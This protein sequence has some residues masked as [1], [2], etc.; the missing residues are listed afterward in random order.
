M[1]E[2]FSQ[3]FVLF[4]VAAITDNIVLNRFLG[5]CPFL[6]VSKKLSS[7]YQ[8]G[9]AVTF[10]MIFSTFITWAINL[11]VLVPFGLEFLKIVSFILIIASLVQF[12]ELYLKKFFSEIY[13]SFGIYLPLITTNCAILGI[14]FLNIQNNHRLAESIFYPLGA[15][16]GFMIAL[17]LMAGIREKLDVADIPK[18]FKGTPIALISAA[19]LALAF[20]GLKTLILSA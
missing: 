10:V 12:V 15:G 4:I 18:P 3:L 5:V 13:D 2:I 16:F 1:I 9:I 19:L 11:F 17:A 6:G 7:A 8:M 20:A 14:A